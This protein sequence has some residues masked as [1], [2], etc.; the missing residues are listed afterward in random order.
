MP[1]SE[2]I[3]HRQNLE[4]LQRELIAGRLP[5]ALLFCGPQAVGKR[6]LAKQLAA[7]INCRSQHPGDWC[8]QCLEC[9][10]IMS[11]QHPDVRTLGMPEGKD[12]KN[13]KGSAEE[14]SEVSTPEQ[15]VPF[16]KIEQMRELV[17]EASMMPF[18]A[19][20]KVFLLENADAMKPETANTLLKT[21]EEPPAT[22]TLIL[23]TSHPD[24][25]LP[26]I[27]SRCQIFRFSYLS[28]QE[29]IRILRREK[30]L[31]QQEAEEK[32]AWAE[33]AVDRALHV[34]PEYQHRLDRSAQLFLE[35]AIQGKPLAR[36]L[37]LLAESA[38]KEE[39]KKTKEWLYRLFHALRKQVIADL[40]PGKA[41][42]LTLLQAE[43]I[44]RA[45]DDV[46]RGLT[47]NI[48][49]QPALE[50]LYLTCRDIAR[51]P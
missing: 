9:R 23:I 6:Y 22:S 14:K 21:L 50:N 51:N 26:T 7:A 10:R 44:S 28:T 49:R 47:V 30:G 45:I 43:A 12:G 18:Y 19:R 16:I 41:P 8:G 1:F 37:E 46:C 4:I 20:Q 5:H 24:S 15:D 33:G 34:D 48:S 27:R 36:I 40:Q 35:S 32:A 39:K 11:D 2:Y 29:I 38:K 25:L 13:R 3:G 31:S 17:E 42:S